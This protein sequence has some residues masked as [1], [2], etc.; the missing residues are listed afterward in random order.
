MR[1][2]AEDEEDGK[3]VGGVVRKDITIFFFCSPFVNQL[4]SFK[5]GTLSPLFRVVSYRLLAEENRK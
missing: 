1:R 5:H 3:G 2:G 4:A